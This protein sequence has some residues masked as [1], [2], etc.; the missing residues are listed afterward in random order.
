M[1]E[2][3]QKPEYAQQLRPYAIDAAD[4]RCLF[5]AAGETLIHQG[6]PVESLYFILEGQVEA[7]VLHADGRRLALCYTV[8]NGPLGDVELLQESSA[9]TAT[10]VA[11]TDV[12]CLAYS[13]AKA[14]RQRDENLIFVRQL[15]RDLTNKLLRSTDRLVAASLT[16]AQSQVCRH[17]LQ[18]RRGIYY[19][20]TLTDIAAA[21]G[22]SYRH[23]Q[24]IIRALLDDGA[25][26]KSSPGI[27]RLDV[28]RLTGLCS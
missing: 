3:Q 24:R 20:G 25:V 11:Q 8:S 6:A 14:R 10:V 13:Y 17:L 7:Q 12:I 19:S 21:T 27:Y 23:I 9:A 18:N 1:R 26:E 15:A 4:C 16:S 5:F 28:E 22:V 2:M